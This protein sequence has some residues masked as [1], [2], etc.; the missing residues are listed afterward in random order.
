ME[1]K[2]QQQQSNPWVQNLLMP[3]LVIG[4]GASITLV[5]NLNS[6]VAIINERQMRDTKDK[7]DMKQDLN[8]I[9]LDIRDL[10]DKAIR[11]ERLQNQ[12]K[13]SL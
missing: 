9:K 6:N 2:A 12:Q 5:L 4:V 1:Q 11:E 7:D 8:Q 13:S 3:L 10:R